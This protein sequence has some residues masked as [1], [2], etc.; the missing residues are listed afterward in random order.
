MSHPMNPL[1]VNLIQELLSKH[2]ED[3]ILSA[4]TKTLK[5]FLIRKS[6]SLMSW[7]N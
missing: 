1:D 5:K 3:N 6:C 7:I 4:P 2:F